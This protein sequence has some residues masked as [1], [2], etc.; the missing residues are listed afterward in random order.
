MS[1]TIKIV[2]EN[3]NLCDL[4]LSNGFL[5]IIP[6]AQATKETDKLV[7]IKIKN[8]CDAKDTIKKV[9]GQPIEEGKIFTNHISD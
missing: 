5:D 7:F 1:K 3:I 8:I 2:E 4:E 9:K 6:K